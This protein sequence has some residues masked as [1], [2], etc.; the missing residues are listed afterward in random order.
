MYV[1]EFVRKDGHDSSSERTVEKSS[2]KRMPVEGWHG[3]RRERSHYIAI[4]R[5][6]LGGSDHYKTDHVRR[7]NKR[8]LRNL[9]E[10]KRRRELQRKRSS[11]GHDM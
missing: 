6:K 1:V 8:A 7:V 2:T 10:K 5:C 9:E 11:K 3:R 4:V